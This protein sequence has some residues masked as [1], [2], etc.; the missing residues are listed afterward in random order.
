[1]E[2]KRVII[3]TVLC[4]IAFGVMFLPGYSELQKIRDKNEQQE[5]NIRLLKARN[6]ELKKVVEDGKNDPLYLE[7]KAREKLGIV[8]KGEVIYRRK[9]AGDALHE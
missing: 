6:E 5:K 7:K 3:F 9:N 1:M 8:K 2:K 4:L